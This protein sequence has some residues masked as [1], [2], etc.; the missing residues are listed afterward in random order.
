VR[1][2]QPLF[3]SRNGKGISMRWLDELMRLYA[4]LAGIPERKANMPVWKHTCGTTLLGE[5]WDVWRVQDWIGQADIRNT[6][7]CSHV[8]NTARNEMHDAFREETMSP[9]AK[10]LKSR[11][12][13]P[14]Q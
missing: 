13:S 3:I 12:Q 1:R 6:M 2:D 11:I 8:V 7:R 10:N 4:K 14:A 5:G 9:E